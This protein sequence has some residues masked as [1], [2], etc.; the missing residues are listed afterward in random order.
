MIELIKTEKKEL[1][2]LV[3]KEIAF[4]LTDKK[5][6]SQDNFKKEVQIKYSIFDKNQ[7]QNIFTI[8]F[9]G[10]YQIDEILIRIFGYNKTRFKIINIPYFELKNS[11]N[12]AVI[13]FFDIQFEK[14]HNLLE[15]I[16]EVDILLL[17]FSEKQKEKLKEIIHKIEPTLSIFYSEDKKDLEIKDFIEK[18]LG[19]G[20][21][22]IKKI[23]LL[24]FKKQ[25]EKFLI[26]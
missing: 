11:V 15:K 17:K 16:K 6:N 23:N 5:Q 26:I 19:S 25:D 2:L 8:K 18:H 3:D 1:I 12:L 20:S 22:N 13:N 14:A 4:F 10:M 7:T 21:K 24:N 9:P